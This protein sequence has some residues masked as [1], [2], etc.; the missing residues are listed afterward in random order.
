MSVLIHKSKS[1]VTNSQ[2]LLIALEAISFKF[3]IS[4]LFDSS[5]G[6]VQTEN[7]NVKVSCCSPSLTLHGCKSSKK[8]KIYE[9]LNLTSLLPIAESTWDISSTVADK[10]RDNIAGR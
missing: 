3:G 2:I 7:V 4:Y 9:S 1:R 10:D 5:T 6:R 8:F